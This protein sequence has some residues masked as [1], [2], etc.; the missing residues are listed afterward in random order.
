MI[1]SQPKKHYQAVI[2]TI[3]SITLVFSLIPS[4]AL[5]EAAPNDITQTATEQPVINGDTAV[6]PAVNNTEQS[7]NDSTNDT[8][9]TKEQPS[10]SANRV[11]ESQQISEDQKVDEEN[12][13]DD[14][15]QANKEPMEEEAQLAATAT[16]DANATA[17]TLHAEEPR[18]ITITVGL[19]S[20]SNVKQDLHVGLTYN[21]KFF[22]QASNTF[23]ND[24]AYASTCLAAAA[25]NSNEGG[26]NYGLKSK[27]IV[28]FLQQIGCNDVKTNDG[29]NYKPMEKANIGVAIGYKDIRVNNTLYRL[30]VFAA[31]GG[32]Y[33]EEWSVNMRVGTEGDATGFQE[34]RDGALGFIMPYIKEHTDKLDG[35][36]NVKIWGSG[37]CRGGTTTNLAMGWLNKWVY[38]RNNGHTYNNLAYTQNYNAEHSVYGASYNQGDMRYTQ[39]VSFSPNK[40]GG[41]LASN[42]NIT[43]D[44]LYAYPVN[45]PFGADGADVENYE[46]LMTG[47]HNLINPDDW[48]PQVVMDWW[49]FKR[50]GYKQDHDITGTYTVDGSLHNR[51]KSV[52]NPDDSSRMSAVN[53]MIGRLKSVD[54]DTAFNSTYFRQH[55]FSKASVIKNTAK[56][57]GKWLWNKIK[58]IWGG[59]Q[60]QLPDIFQISIDEKGEGNKFYSQGKELKYNQGGYY[61]EFMKFLLNSAGFPESG[62][63][64]RKYYVQNYQDAFVDLMD[65]VLGQPLEV[66]EK[67]GKVA[68][69]QIKAAF[70]QMQDEG[71]QELKNTNRILGA[72]GTLTT[73][74]V[75]TYIAYV[76]AAVWSINDSSAKLPTDLIGRTLKLTFNNLG[77][78]YTDNQVWRASNALGKLAY[79]FYDKEQGIA[80]FCFF[81]ALTMY[82]AGSS[83]PQSHW[84][85]QS[86]AW[87]AQCKPNSPYTK[88]LDEVKGKQ[89]AKAASTDGD[90]LKA[91]A[92]ITVHEVY[93]SFPEEPESLYDNGLRTNGEIVGIM[94][95]PDSYYDESILVT[96]W[97]MY[98][99]EDFFDGK[100]PLKTVSED[101]EIG[102]NDPEYI[103]LTPNVETVASKHIN[104]WLNKAMTGFDKDV[105]IGEFDVYDGGYHYIAYTSLPEGV[106]DE[107]FDV[108]YYGD[109]PNL[110]TKEGVTLQGWVTEAEDEDEMTGFLPDDF[111]D[112][113]SLPEGDVV[114]LYAAW[115]DPLVYN[116]RYHANRSDSDDYVVDDVQFTTDDSKLEITGLSEDDEGMKNSS[117]SFVGWN[118]MPDGSGTWVATGEQ[119]TLD[120]LNLGTRGQY[121]Q[122]LQALADLQ[123]E[124]SPSYNTEDTDSNPTAADAFETDLEEKYTA[125]LYAQWASPEPAPAP[126]GKPTP[127]NNTTNTT[128]QN[129]AKTPNTGDASTTPQM[130]AIVM[131]FA[132]ASLYAARRLRKRSE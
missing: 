84:P 78:K 46:G 44:D 72:F 56:K 49:G 50:Y 127:A 35:T 128:N 32:G 132:L 131:L 39:T 86:L 22:E 11:D 10:E 47:F 21:D 73:T 79:G 38:E 120:Q 58:K 5:A 92:G 69:G 121:A 14:K 1:H 115:L 98:S 2:S 40:D 31:R 93:S 37:Y 123:T 96:S 17:N 76:V 7:N 25:D 82:K 89:E 43:N 51:D 61:Q 12:K 45:C 63:E 105:L 122:D 102:E 88:P 101:Y 113:D 34:A 129:K 85:E 125:D 15:Q 67:F 20:E 94:D 119:A 59:K 108:L 26:N 19:P 99:L 8:D 70:K 13:P 27:N 6:D 30:F 28:S 75:G 112:Y 48:F 111:L 54:T 124:E 23:N 117:K 100:P 91:E 3:L 16:S 68:S 104:L 57:V 33:E 95:M 110:V 24:L 4:Q 9:Q 74:T 97:N 29:Y 42:V 83:I 41:Y 55:Y 80:K 103:V 109:N 106:S 65:W 60:D 116:V 87:F 81:H 126:D 52:W 90:A 107:G 118:T 36:V 130:A 114:D 77:I 71:V 64:A 18:D 53:G 62:T 66:R